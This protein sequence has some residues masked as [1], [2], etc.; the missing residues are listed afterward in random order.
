MIT[1]GTLAALVVC[2]AV[3]A[4][5]D[6]QQ[7]SQLPTFARDPDLLAAPQSSKSIWSG[8]YVGSEVFAFS[9]KGAKGGFGGAVYAGYARE[10]PNNV[11]LGVSA[12]TGY[13][14]S[15]WP[16]S[17]FR[18]FDFGAT[19]VTLG[20]D[21]G[22]LTPYVTSG[23]VLAKP[24][25]WRS[26][27]FPNTNDSLNGLFGSGSGSLRAAGTVGAGFDYAVTNNLHVG[28]GVAVGTGGILVPPPMP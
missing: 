9:S 4:Y 5:A 26:S 13:A 6:S 24:V 22:R 28:M 10:L 8:L 18:G 12:A 1:K 27:D 16:Y 23:L 17:R 11:I 21:M 2:A 25:T 3:P 7:A 19:N 15:L 20:Y 14:P